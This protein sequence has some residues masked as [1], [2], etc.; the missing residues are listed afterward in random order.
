M[1]VC[2]K[3]RDDG[4]NNTKLNIHN[5]IPTSWGYVYM[6]N[7][8][9]FMPSSLPLLHIAMCCLNTSSSWDRTQV[10]E[11]INTFLRTD[12]SLDHSEVVLRMN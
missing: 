4:I 1:A 9:F 7:F 12:G 5:P 10:W 8:V 3:G 2:N 6:F 11:C